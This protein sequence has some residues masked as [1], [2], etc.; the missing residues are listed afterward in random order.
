MKTLGD[1]TLNEIHEICSRRDDCTGCQFYRTRRNITGKLYRSCDVTTST[2][3]D[4]PCD[5]NQDA[6][7]TE[8]PRP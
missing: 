8:V 4:D 2:W 7:K 6:L 1:Y 5:W 3:C